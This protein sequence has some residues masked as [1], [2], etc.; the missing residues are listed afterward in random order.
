[1]IGAGT[2]SVIGAGTGS[3]IGAGTGSVIGAGTGSVI[4]DFEVVASASVVALDPDLYAGGAP[5]DG[6]GVAS[7]PVEVG[8]RVKNEAR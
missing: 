4:V 8:S 5:A 7:G 2:G 1:M 6:A 3:V